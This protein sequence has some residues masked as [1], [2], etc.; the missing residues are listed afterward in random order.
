MQRIE[1]SKQMDPTD[2]PRRVHEAAGAVDDFIEFLG[3]NDTFKPL[4]DA[5]I[6]SE[7]GK[8]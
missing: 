2:Y 3:K 8:L 7:V 5:L 1:I 6:P 4:V